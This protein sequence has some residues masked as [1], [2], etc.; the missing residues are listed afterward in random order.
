V[1]WASA[2]ASDD[3]TI[4]DGHQQEPESR[5]AGLRENLLRESSQ[6]RV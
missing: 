3:G 1:A 4:A 2:W 6:H 5:F